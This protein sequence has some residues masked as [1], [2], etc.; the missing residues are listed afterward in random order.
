MCEIINNFHGSMKF[1][2]GLYNFWVKF[3]FIEAIFSHTVH[4]FQVPCMTR[5]NYLENLKLPKPEEKKRIFPIDF[6]LF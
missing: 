6:F 4:N 2:S 3:V 1:M 5:Y